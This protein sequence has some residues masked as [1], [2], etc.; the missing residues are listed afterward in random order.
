MSLLSMENITKGVNAA[1]DLVQHFLPM[2]GVNPA[3]TATIDKVVDTLQEMAPM[4]TGQIG[5]T[6]EGV[7][8]IVE[9]LSSNPATTAEQMAK[10]KAFDKKVDDAWDAIESKI[11]PD[12]PKSA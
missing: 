11:D 6:Y 9:S 1:V 5:D 2:I 7:K 10:L 12:A 4:I 3:A 8:N